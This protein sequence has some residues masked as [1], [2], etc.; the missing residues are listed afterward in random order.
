MGDAD[1]GTKGDGGG[2][3]ISANF[4]GLVRVRREKWGRNNAGWPRTMETDW[5]M[6]EGA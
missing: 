6:S 3:S 2:G 5:G 4:W 1:G